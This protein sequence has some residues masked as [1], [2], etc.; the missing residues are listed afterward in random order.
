MI[1]YGD[2]P[3]RMDPRAALDGV[4]GALHRL[5]PMPAGLDRHAALVSA[6]IAAG[7]LAQGLADAE[8]A[9]RGR[10]AASPGPDAAM[11]LLARLAGA[12]WSSWQSGFSSLYPPP[13]AEIVALRAAPMP[14]G[15]ETKRAEGFAYYA[16]YPEA[17]ALA[18]AALPEASWR[19]IGLR[20]IGTTLA[21]MA[22][23]GL[24]A[25]V[26]RTLRPVGHPFRREIAVE[27]GL[28]ADLIAPSPARFALVDEGPG[29]SGS[30]LGAATGFLQD[31]GVEPGRIH[32]I[33]GHGGDP[34]P[35][36]DPR[37]RHLW[38]RVAR[39]PASFED[40]LLRAER[41]EHRLEGWA[42]AL[43]GP[44]EAP[45]REISGGAWRSGPEGGWPPVH[46]FME[47]R[48]F[49]HRARGGSWLLKFAGL[50]AEGEA[51]ASRAR[52]LHE[53][54][55]TPPVAGFLHGFLVERWVEKGRL[56]DPAATDR[57]AL[58]AHLGRY[59]GFRA[60]TM[61]AAPESGATAKALWEM[62][63]ANA[64]EGLGEAAALAME[65]W[66]PL[67][68]R[69]GTAIRRVHT[70]NRLHAWE[71]LVLP[72]GGLL[73]T[74]AVD[75]AAS[76]DLIGCQDIAWD[77]AGARVEFRLSSGERAALC[78]RVT[79]ASGR[80]V[81]EE[82]LAFLTPCYL[83]FQLGYYSMAAGAWGGNAVEAARARAA[84]ARYAEA[85]SRALQPS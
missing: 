65:R 1:V 79:Q 29:L 57:A 33:P 68:P 85:L 37:I 4:E 19:V 22:A 46:P 50:G 47:R 78:E 15:I 48:K 21:A 81:D 82:L 84:A 17:Y 52:A 76:H 7:E 59:L 30:S 39:H 41:P 64:R 60:R 42:A 70:D 28:A 77:V 8:F 63:R 34:G 72:G 80:A 66:K 45:L 61:P 62:A 74:D 2:A 69:L 53:A 6:L 36:A 83:A 13:R 5:Q 32:L 18:G 55:F 67:L 16:L 49:L 24:G 23:V 14:A 51:A 43:L 73:K 3:R 54:G 9:A 31:R 38:S 10:D 11:A 71:W 75:H 12:A 26:P 56:L 44:G 27:E 20:S 35:E 25:P 40:L 58:V